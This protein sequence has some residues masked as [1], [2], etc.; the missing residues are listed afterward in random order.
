MVNPGE[1]Q[2]NNSMNTRQKIL[3][4]SPSEVYKFS[5]RE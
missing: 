1:P 5:P 4:Q 3:I 2:Y